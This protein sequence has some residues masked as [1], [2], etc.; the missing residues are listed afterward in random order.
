MDWRLFLEA[1]EKKGLKNV[2]SIDVGARWGIG[3]RWTG[4]ENLVEIIGFDPDLAECERL[5][6][7]SP[8]NVKYVPFALGERHLRTLLH[9]AK[10]PGCSSLYPPNDNVSQLLPE[11]ECIKLIRTEEIEVISFDEWRR[12]SGAPAPTV[13]KLDAQGGELGVLAGAVEALRSTQLLE[14]EVEFN[15]LYDGQPLFSDVDRFLRANDFVLYNIAHR[16]YYSNRDLPGMSM[17]TEDISWFD[18]KPIYGELGC[19]QL[20]WAHA[21]FVRSELSPASPTKIPAKQ[22]LAAAVVA[23]AYGLLD[24]AYIALRKSAGEFDEDEL[25][26]LLHLITVKAQKATAKRRLKR[27]KRVIFRS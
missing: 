23:I 18:S 21:Y 26:Q 5:N 4:L 13:M 11:S 17:K 1:S 10:D 22:A 19:G 2:T 27:A 8:Q 24:L 20:Y 16:V 12:S 15:P 7:V 14:I 25:K 9:I 6:A 3:D